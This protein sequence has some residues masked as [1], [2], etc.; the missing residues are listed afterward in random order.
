MDM[1][2]LTDRYKEFI[3]SLQ[4]LVEE[5]KVPMSRIND[6][7]TRILRVKFA[8]GMMVAEPN[9]WPN[10]ELQQ[11]FGSQAHRNILF[12]QLPN[13]NFMLYSDA[14]ENTT[15]GALP[16]K[17]G[18]VLTFVFDCDMDNVTPTSQAKV[19]K[20]GAASGAAAAADG[21]ASQAA[22]TPAGYA[23]SVSFNLGKKR[24]ALNLQVRN[25]AGAAGAAFP[26]A[27]TDTMTASTLRKASFRTMA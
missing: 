7:V 19:P 24:L 20:A 17:D 18:D 5:G 14:S 26:V 4:E 8:M 23:G 11:E 21:P 25:P 15:T 12:T 9:L 13:S 10:K 16:M 1:V 6:A 2:M 22:A 3:I 27:L